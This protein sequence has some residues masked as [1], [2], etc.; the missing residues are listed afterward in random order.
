MKNKLKKY[1]LKTTFITTGLLLA[2]KN[3]IYAIGKFNQVECLYGIPKPE[4]EPNLLLIFLKN[5]GY[6][7]TIPIIFAL[8][9][10]FYWKRSKAI[11]AEKIALTITYVI[12]GITLVLLFNFEKILNFIF[13]IL[14]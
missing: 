8:G 1:L 13:S 6:Y 2:L 11:K 14:Y 10:I 9:L 4:P 5:L 7:L 12:I 3:S